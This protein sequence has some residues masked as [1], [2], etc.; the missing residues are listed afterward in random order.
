MFFYS[1]RLNKFVYNFPFIINITFLFIRLF[2][3]VVKNRKV[4]MR[5]LKEF[6]RL[7]LRGAPTFI[8]IDD[9]QVPVITYPPDHR[10]GGTILFLFRLLSGCTC[11]FL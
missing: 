4:G 3:H 11:I 9:I 1:Q 8:P 10:V 7:K 6:N 5:I 2:N